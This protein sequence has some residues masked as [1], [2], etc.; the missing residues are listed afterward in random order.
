MAI[1]ILSVTA[2][3][4]V[5]Q[6]KVLDHSVYDGWKSIRTP[7][8]TKDGAWLTYGIGPQ[9]GDGALF[10]LNVK[11]SKEYRIDRGTT[12]QISQDGHYAV[13]TVAPKLAETKKARKDKVA[14]DA[15]PK[16]SVTILDLETGARTDLPKATSFELAEEDHGRVIYAMDTPAPAA[17]AAPAG[18]AKPPA[19]VAVPPDDEEWDQRRQGA[20]PAGAAGAGTGAPAR[21]QSVIL[22]VRDLKTGH[23][24][25]I[26]SVSQ[27]A[28]S[29]DGSLLIYTKTSANAKDRAV[30]VD[31][32]ATSKKSTL[33][34]GNV[35][36]VKLTWHDKSKTLAFLTDKE[37]DSKSLA[38][39]LWH[40]GEATSKALVADGA[41]GIPT[42][43]ILTDTSNLSVTEHGV[44][45]TFTVSPKP[46]EAKPDTTP[47]DEKVS[48]DIWHYQDPQIQSAQLL[49]L[50]TDRARSIS[51]LVNLKSG[52]LTQ[53][54]TE[55]YPSV[56]ISNKGEGRYG[57]ATSNVPYRIES[58]W[59]PGN[60]DTYLV[61]T[62]TGKVDKVREHESGNLGFSPSGRYMVG[63][64]PAEH[65]FYSFDPVAK[66]RNWL[67][68]SIAFAVHDE[69]HDTPD[70]AAPYGIAGW[71]NND[72]RILIYDAFDVWSF[73]PSGRNKP[74]N[75]S[76][77]W[78]RVNQTRIR[79]QQTDVDADTLDTSKPLLVTLFDI[80]SK[81]GGYGNLDIQS[82]RITK[83]IYGDKTYTV[84]TRAKNADVQI[85]TEQTFVEYPDIW[86][87]NTKFEGA[88]RLTDANPQQKEYNW[89]KS[90]LIRWTSNDGVPLQGLLIK[91]ENFDYSKKYPMITYFYERF[92]DNLNRYSAP[93]PSA[94][95]VNF[96][97]Y[98]SNGYVLF[99]PDIPYK[100]G[101]PG[102]SAMS[103]IMPGVQAVLA[104][105]YI[106]PK[107]LGL[108]GQSWGGYQTAYLITE[109]TMFSAACSGA[110]VA[111]MFSAYGGIRYGSGVLRQMQ[112]EHGQSRLAGTPWEKPMRYF[113]NSPLFFL[114]KVTTPLLMMHNDKDGSVPWTQG[115]ELYSGMRRLQKPCWMVTYNGEDHNLV[116]RKNRKDWS[117]RMQQFF[118][119]Y[120]KGAPQPVWMV[121]GVAA[122]DKGK[123]MGLEIQ[124]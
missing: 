89:G 36:Y 85:F 48:V 55:L 81:A 68:K 20:R 93:A 107:K 104:R 96:P 119:H 111:D 9:E 105:G 1:G 82:K 95:T 19:P 21:L 44:R 17:A 37:K 110:A 29:K 4:A 77:G 56:S 94:S 108:Q 86:L 30:V 72:D 33:S 115:V 42:G 88:K 79:V 22:T 102:E 117:I 47:D 6:K 74:E 3:T 76:G 70:D 59:D 39:H 112:Y 83:L 28:V 54:G 40:P 64:D 27:R 41:T 16:T 58:T 13:A 62:E 18:G 75:I 23:E 10:V 53:L 31:E 121:K 34:Q 11:T 5:A 101:Y 43:Y 84:S 66:K 90:E 50:A 2:A 15:M 46:A 63:Y 38:I 65:A 99:V 78:G 100:T 49:Q 118:D 73:D 124:K 120:L 57:V 116:E 113:E 60:S 45:F 80:D 8:L 97:M 92:S 35:K 103:A 122:V 7:Q 71:T 51:M 98:A 69:L 32:L 106:D 14:A 67:T 109:T 123:T 91:P 12:V 52:K 25:T 87:S 61:D 114:D 24:E 26:P